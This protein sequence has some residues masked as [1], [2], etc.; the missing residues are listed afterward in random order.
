[1]NPRLWDLQRRSKLAPQQPA[2]AP[3]QI[4]GLGATLEAAIGR[5]IA[6]HADVL[7]Q[8]Q[9][10]FERDQTRQQQ[11][12]QRATLEG[13]PSPALDAMAER[14][15]AAA[16]ARLQPATATALTASAALVPAAAA[17]PAPIRG[18]P[19][20]ASLPTISYLRDIDGRISHSEATFA[21]GRTLRLRYERDINGRIGRA[22]P[23]AST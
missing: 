20:P 21:D 15:V 9:R 13:Q 3:L 6:A 1:M 19:E 18:A 16:L 12:F 10:E 14:A 8:R 4:D 23:E 7:N 5:A 2:P 11:N 17:A 22:I